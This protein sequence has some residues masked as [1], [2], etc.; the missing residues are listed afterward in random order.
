MRRGER[1]TQIVTKRL[2]IRLVAGIVEVRKQVMERWMV[3]PGIRSP[4]RE[5]KLRL[6]QEV[7]LRLL[8]GNPLIPGSIPDNLIKQGVTQIRDTVNVIASTEA[9]DGLV[10]R[11][12][13][14]RPVPL[15]ADQLSAAQIVV[16]RN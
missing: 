1:R 11:G 4:S 2:E 7:T 16:Q 13:V 12:G 6:F 14:A 9:C 5:I 8:S 10:H 15:L 3:G